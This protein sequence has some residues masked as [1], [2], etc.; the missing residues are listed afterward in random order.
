MPGSARL[1]DSL[2]LKQ[3]TSRHAN[4]KRLFGAICA[5][6]AVVLEPWGLMKR[7]QV[8]QLLLPVKI[9]KV[10]FNLCCI[11][12]FKGCLILQDDLSSSFH[13]QASFISSSQI[14]HTSLGGAHYK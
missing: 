5:A 12:R 9:C 10:F 13:A 14:K 6:P 7:K 4:G 11:L 3:I 2:V 8:Y 1:R